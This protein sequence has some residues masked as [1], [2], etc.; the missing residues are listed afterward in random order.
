MLVRLGATARTA[1]AP[2]R[3]RG[4]G[5]EPGLISSAAVSARDR[6][7]GLALHEARAA[8]QRVRVGPARA[9]RDEVG[10]RGSACG[11]R[12]ISMSTLARSSAAERRIRDAVRAPWRTP[13]RSLLEPALRAADAREQRAVRSGYDGFTASARRARPPPSRSPD[14]NSSRASITAV[15]GTSRSRVRPWQ[16]AARRRSGRARG[17]RAEQALRPRELAVEFDAVSSGATAGGGSRLPEPRHGEPE[18]AGQDTAGCLDR[19]GDVRRRRWRGRARTRRAAARQA[20]ASKMLT[21]W[22]RAALNCQGRA[23]SSSRQAVPR[24][25]IQPPGGSARSALRRQSAEPRA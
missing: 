2:S 1:A 12:F 22:V 19:L 23:L 20:E 17:R 14:S 10:E 4:R 5:G 21:G 11:R 15:C 25:A 24:A 3:G 18:I 6:R 8:E 7:G 9:A 13:P 16:R